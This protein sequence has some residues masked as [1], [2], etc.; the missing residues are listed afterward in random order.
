MSSRTTSGR[1]VRRAAPG[2]QAVVGRPDVVAAPSR[3]SMARLSAASRLSSTTRTR[4]ARAGG[5]VRRRGRRGRR[6]RSLATGRRQPHDELA[7]P[8]RPLALRVDAAAVHLDEPLDQRQ[9][10]AQPALRALERAS[11]WVNMSNTAGSISG[12]MPMPVV[13]HRAPRPRRPCRSAVS[14]I[15]AAR[16]G[17]LAGVVEQ[18]AE[19]LGQPRRVGVQ[20]DRLGRQVRRSSS[21]RP[22][23]SAGGWPRRACSTTGASSTALPAELELVAA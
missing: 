15:A 22:P 12:G 23:R 3:S 17:V 13:A 19:H 11:T 7:A 6:A 1:N 16:L 10:D 8:P 21:C 2:L 4:P 14:Q 5:L 20:A 18:V 9:A